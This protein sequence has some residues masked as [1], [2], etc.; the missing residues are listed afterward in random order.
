MA[1]GPCEGGEG[2]ERDAQAWF[3][4][5]STRM[6]VALTFDDGPSREN[7][8][9]ILDVLAEHDVKATFFVL[10][11][12]SARMRELLERIDA[13][14]HDIG[15]HSWSHPS[16]RSLWHSQIHEEICDT[17]MFIRDTLGKQPTLF[18]PPFGRYAPSAVPL[19]GA[20]G[21]DLV[22]WSV[23][24]LD[25]GE[26]DPEV[27]ADTVIRQAKPGA[28]I[29]LHDRRAVTVHALPHIIRGLRE[30]GFS[31]EPV[32]ALLGRDAYESDGLATDVRTRPRRVGARTR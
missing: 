24:S 9:R 16:F 8:P 23:D 25:W 18:R 7:T 29:L 27:I 11:Q 12:R 20:L 15:N 13:A 6:A 1:A 19:V 4:G 30:R 2:L 3:D 22:L 5:S 14:G 17:H 10:G 28:I 21:Y 32:S 26:E 31:I